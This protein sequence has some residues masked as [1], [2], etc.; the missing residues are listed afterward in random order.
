MLT[1]NFTIVDFR[2][3]DVVNSSETLLIALEDML[4][5]SANNVDTEW[6]II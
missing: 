5:L 3:Y 6:S 4:P 1:Y 2:K